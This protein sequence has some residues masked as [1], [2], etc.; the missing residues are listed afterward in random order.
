MSIQ[1]CSR[2]LSTV[3]FA[4]ISP[5][6][7]ATISG[8]KALR[9]PSIIQTRVCQIHGTE[10]T[11]DQ[12]S[13]TIKNNM[14]N[15][16]TVGSGISDA[17]VCS[18]KQDDSN[19]STLSEGTSEVR[20]DAQEVPANRGVAE[21]TQADKRPHCE[22]KS[23]ENAKR[24]KQVLVE[25]VNYMLL[26]GTCTSIT[27]TVSTHTCMYSI[28]QPIYLCIYILHIYLCVSFLYLFYGFNFASGIY[29][30][31]NTCMYICVYANAD[32]YH[33]CVNLTI[34]QAL[35]VFQI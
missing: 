24:L 22:D 13:G 21:Q 33:W 34:F 5:P 9:A 14:D 6:I 12:F 25:F 23:S 4:T 31:F 2:K 16:L 17:D 27:F 8:L 28:V 35:L 26:G 7:V 32:N 19:V 29:L 10:H 1:Q 20:D 30:L 18:P 11:R 15:R 3:H